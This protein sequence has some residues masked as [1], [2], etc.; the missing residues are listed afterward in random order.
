MTHQSLD[1]AY[2]RASTFTPTTGELAAIA[3][4][5]ALFEIAGALQRLGTG[6]AFTNGMGAIEYLGT[7]IRDG[8]ARI[9]EALAEANK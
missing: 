8:F 9:A 3:T 7:E 6:D 1:M 4:A 5:E 2:K